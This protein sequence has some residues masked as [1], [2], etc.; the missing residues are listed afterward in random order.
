[1]LPRDQVAVL[2]FDKPIAE[3]LRVAQLSG[4]SRPPVREGT[5]DQVRGMILVREWLWQLQAL[6]VETPFAPFMRPALEFY[7]KMS[8]HAT[9]EHFRMARSHLAAVRD[10]EGKLAGIVTFS[11][12]LEEIVGGIRDEMDIGL[13]SIAERKA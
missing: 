9:I 4:H 10:G 11:D 3:N 12:V 1:M 7:L 8:I 2:W 13:G 6:G 5:L